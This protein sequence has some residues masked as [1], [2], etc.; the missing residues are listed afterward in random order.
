[1]Y[2]IVITFLNVTIS[3]FTSKLFL[4][5][6]AT[7]DT[8]KRKEKAIR[9]TYGKHTDSAV[10]TDRNNVPEKNDE[11]MKYNGKIMYS[12]TYLHNSKIAVVIASCEAHI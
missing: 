5:T 9:E 8:K 11:G 2:Q 12:Q 1:M 10:P 4:K 6:V 7:K 3:K